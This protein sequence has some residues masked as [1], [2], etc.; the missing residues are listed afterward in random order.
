MDFKEITDEKTLRDILMNGFSIDSTLYNKWNE[1]TLF[2]ENVFYIAT[3]NNLFEYFSLML[4]LIKSTVDDKLTYHC[5]ID[6]QF[7]KNNKIFDEQ[8]FDQYDNFLDYVKLIGLIKCSGNKIIK[9]Y[10]LNKSFAK[11]QINDCINNII[12]KT[13]YLA[14]IKFFCEEYNIPKNIVK[15]IIF[16]SINGFL[17]KT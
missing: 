8:T 15:T 3:K 6:I 5:E 1:Q 12:N 4:R 2:K 16:N 13:D 14:Q 9:N 7:Y 17:N 11:S 10:K